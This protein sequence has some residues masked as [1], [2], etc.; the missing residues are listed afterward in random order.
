MERERLD[1]MMVKR[2]LAESRSQAQRLVMAGQVW[3]EGQRAL[4]AGELFPSEAQI[5]VHSAPRYVSRGGEKLEAALDTFQISVEDLVCADV[6][7]CTGGFTDCLLQRGARLVYA[8]EV[9]KG[10]LHWKLRQDP[11]VV[12]ME[13]T[14][15]RYLSQ[16]PQ[17]VQLVTID[18][19]FIS[20]RLILPQVRRWF[21]D[22]QADASRP[23]G[24]VIALVKPQFEAG[25]R[26]ATRGRGVIRDA[27]VHRRVLQEVLEFALSQGFRARGLIRSPLLGPKGNVEFLAWLQVAAG[28]PSTEEDRL[29]VA[30][31]ISQALPSEEK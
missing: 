21:E 9:G 6:G 10:L 31:L 7:A 2:G 18:V 4:K 5:V 14:N 13:D 23:P 19:S 29:A 27:Q 25:R 24:T 20:L 26:E 30:A 28:L 8:I 12:V 16:L 11:R 15:A 1:V 22:N 3:V 17:P